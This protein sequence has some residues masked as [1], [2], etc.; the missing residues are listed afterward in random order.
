MT[1]LE[2]CYTSPPFSIAAPPVDDPNLTPFLVRRQA[3]GW[4][5]VPSRSFAGL[6]TGLFAAG[7]AFM[8][9]LSTIFF[10]AASSAFWFG[11]GFLAVAAYSAG[12]AVWTWRRRHTPLRVEPGGRVSHG[13]REL[14]A[15]G[16]VR[17]IR[18]RTA[19]GGDAGEYEV[20]L[21]I[22]G[23]RDV[24]LPEPYFARYAT[25]HGA[26]PFAAKLA[27]LLGVSLVDKT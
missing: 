11:F 21:E 17:A 5:F 9:Y 22:A 10:R 1:A 13:H 7:A 27:E 2:L 26:R 20:S 18:I 16:S 12:L 6:A 4:L 25:R 14:A 8:V 24:F 3:D 15:P 23:G 19:R